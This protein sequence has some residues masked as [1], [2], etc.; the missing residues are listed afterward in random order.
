[1]TSVTPAP[2]GVVLTGAE[3][4]AANEMTD[5]LKALRFLVA[6]WKFRR[7]TTAARILR[8]AIR[9]WLYRVRRRRILALLAVAKLIVF[10]LG[11]PFRRWYVVTHVSELALPRPTTLPLP[12]ILA[13]E[14][15]RQ[16]LARN[17]ER[18]LTRPGVLLY[19]PPRAARAIPLDP[20][21]PDE[22]PTSPLDSSSEDE[23]PT[24]PGTWFQGK[25]PGSEPAP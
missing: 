15:R 11:G 3:R 7:L 19:R 1:M 20:N 10:S 21:Q 17:T 22:L 12:E 4:T 8:R 23:A 6:W 25:P 18:L 14:S 2:Q 9:R 13:P 5:R 16:E 24:M